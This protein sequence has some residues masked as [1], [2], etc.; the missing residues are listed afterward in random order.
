MRSTSMT[1]LRYQQNFASDAKTA[2]THQGQNKLPN[3][4]QNKSAPGQG[5]LTEKSS[6]HLLEGYTRPRP[7]STP[8]LAPPWLA[9]RGKQSALAHSISR[10][11]TF[12][13]HPPPARASPPPRRPL[14]HR[15]H[16]N[17]RRQLL[18]LRQRRLAQAHHHPRRP[19]LR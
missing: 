18:P 5:A 6:E 19:H 3:R 4:K 12:P 14:Q 1:S 9:V 13:P 16:R 8:I 11:A 7:Q 2:N 17:P 15:P 10:V